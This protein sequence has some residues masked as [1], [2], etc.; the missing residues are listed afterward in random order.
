M[1]SQLCGAQAAELGAGGRLGLAA[2]GLPAAA[3][4]QLSYPA[5]RGPFPDAKLKVSVIQRWEKGR[6][7]DSPIRRV[8]ER[9]F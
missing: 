7:W 6:K 2:L 4:P 5:T 1:L 3:L 9:L 8:G